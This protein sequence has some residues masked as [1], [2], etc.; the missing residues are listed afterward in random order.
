MTGTDHVRLSPNEHAAIM[1]RLNLPDCIASALTDAFPG[2]KPTVSDTYEEVLERAQHLAILVGANDRTIPPIFTDLDKAILVDAVEG[3]TYA[4][5]FESH[6]RKEQN[7]ARRVLEM[8]AKKMIFAKIADEIDV[9][10]A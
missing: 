5:R 8:L 1:D 6:Q 9:P 10:S 7:A 3:S 2:E 4:A